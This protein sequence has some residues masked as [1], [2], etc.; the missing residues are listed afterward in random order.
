MNN[1]DKLL[2]VIDQSSDHFIEE[3]LNFA[4]SLS[5]QYD[6]EELTEAEN[7]DDYGS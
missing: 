5:E 3:L 7:K 2:Q 1:K 4:L 6:S